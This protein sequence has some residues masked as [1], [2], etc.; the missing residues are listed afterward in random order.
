MNRL[1]MIHR[2]APARPLTTSARLYGAWQAAEDQL[3]QAS[4]EAHGPAWTVVSFNVPSRSPTDCRKRHLQLSATLKAERLKDPRAFHAVFQDGF[5]LATE[6]RFVKFPVETVEA[7]PLAK[8]CER[9][10]ER[11]NRQAATWSEQE[12]LVVREA[13]ETLGANWKLIARRLSKR[14]PE[15]TR[16]MMED[17]AAALAS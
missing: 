2:A 5:E 10:P 11:T 17:W 12:R 7:T 14:T 1:G 9:L 3:L 15:E 16:L 8:L 6:G 13:Y 4:F